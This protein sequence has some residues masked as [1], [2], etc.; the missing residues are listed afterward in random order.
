MASSMH[1]ANSAFVNRD[2]TMLV[3]THIHAENVN[4]ASGL[5]TLSLL[6]L[7]FAYPPS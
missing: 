1:A 6:L 7:S 4:I 5:P 3:N 2:G